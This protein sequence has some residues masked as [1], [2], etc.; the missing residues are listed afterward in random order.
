V[1]DQRNVADLGK[2]EYRPTARVVEL[3][4]GLTVR[5][6]AIF[7]RAFPLEFADAVAVLF[8]SLQCREVVVQPLYDLLK[9][10][11]VNLF[12]VG[13]LL[14][15]DSVGPVVPRTMRTAKP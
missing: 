1:V 8:P 6:R 12:E 9:D 15:E 7:V 5:D 10:L 3:E 2:R 4:A 14:L 13:P 11:R